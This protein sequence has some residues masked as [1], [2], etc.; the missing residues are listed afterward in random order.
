LTYHM[1]GGLTWT[2]A[3]IIDYKEVDWLAWRLI[4][5]IKRENKALKG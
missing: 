1:Q 5:Q 4:D 2:E 3:E